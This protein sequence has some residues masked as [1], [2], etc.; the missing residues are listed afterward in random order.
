MMTPASFDPARADHVA[1]YD[2]LPLWSAHAGAMLLEH[3]PL[4][5]RRALDLGCGA[6]FPLLEL[7]ERLGRGA[8]VTGLDPWAHGLAR[9]AAKRASWPVPQVALVRGD[10]AAMPFRAGSFD[11]VVSNLG[12][13]NFADPLAALRECRRVLAEDGRLAF[14]T[15]VTGHF[16]EWYA[17][18]ADALQARGDRAAID[19]LREH[20]A[21]R[22]TARTLESRL[23]ACG[24]AVEATHEHKVLWRFRDARAVLEHHFMRLGFVAG[25]REVAG[26]EADAVFREACA[27]LDARAE[28]TGEVRLSVPLL[29]VLA[30]RSPG[31][32]GQA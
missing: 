31:G 11:L 18:L 1:L 4:A 30:R 17:A 23:E 12:V 13:N 26:A 9:A 2:E 8:Q 21:H 5:A 28:A 27:R 7:A 19:R 3:V 6:G 20:V 24:F 25:W 29:C 10:G 14:T 16:A 22:G 15:N 32:P